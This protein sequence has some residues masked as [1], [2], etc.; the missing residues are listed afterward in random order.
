MSLDALKFLVL[1]EADRMLD[2]GFEPEIRLLVQQ[3]MP[4]K[5]IRQTLMFSATF[6]SEIQHLASDFL[7]E[8]VLISVGIMGSANQDIRQEFEQ[9]SK[10]QKSRKLLEYLNRDLNY[11]QSDEQGRYY[12]KTLVFVE[13]KRNADFIASFLSQ[14]DLK[15]TS[16]HGDREQREREE[17]LD[18]FRH[19]RCPI[20]V[21]TAVAARG[22]DIKGVDHVINYDLPQEIEDY[23]HRIG[24][25]G[26]VGNPGRATSFYD[27]EVDRVL[28]APLVKILVDAFQEVPEWLQ[29]DAKRHQP[30]ASTVSTAA[31]RAPPTAATASSPS[32][33]WGDDGVQVFESKN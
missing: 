25:T 17:A 1:D 15:A 4:K 6:P 22:L 2:M 14:N 9:V 12:M 23:V 18:D 5:H 20:L 8:F 11:Y 29:V 33:D 26:R 28:A 7:K 3:Y 30:L 32:D 16:I 31:R 21:A 13:R 24:R 10:Q 19:G 27:P